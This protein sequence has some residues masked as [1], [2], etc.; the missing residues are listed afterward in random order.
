MSQATT[1]SSGPQ[2]PGAQTATKTPTD[3]NLP[4]GA[5]LAFSISAIGSG[6]SMRVSDP[7]LP[8][9]AREFSLTLGH[10]ALVITMPA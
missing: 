8:G 2:A 1:I 4:R 6:I 9:L 7:L 10:A 5:L 3:I